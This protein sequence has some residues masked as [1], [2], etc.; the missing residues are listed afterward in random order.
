VRSLEEVLADWRGDAAVLRRQGHEA[1][2]ALLE[3][4][5]SQAAEAAHEFIT[6]LSEGEAQLRSGRSPAWLRR[7][8]PE[9][10]QAGHAKRVKRA[11]LYRMLIVPR[12]P[13]LESAREAGRRAARVA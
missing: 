2:A 3:R 12:R 6:W 9:W 1:Q 5:A 11:R 7:Q 13:N 10:E 4:L 8:F